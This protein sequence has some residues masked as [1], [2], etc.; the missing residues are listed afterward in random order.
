MSIEIN[1]DL[2]SDEKILTKIF[3]KHYT[4]IVE[5]SSG[6]KPSSLRDSTNPLLDETTV[7]K[8]IDT[9]RDYPT[10]IAIKSS[11]TQNWKSSL[12]HAITQ[13]INKIINSLNSDKATGPDCMAV[14][15]I[16]LSANVTDIRYICQMWT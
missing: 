14:K 8:I 11:V 12:P 2:V 10:V 3:S 13:D 4:N 6:T 9:Y 7:E 16:K 15:F 5:K 1:D